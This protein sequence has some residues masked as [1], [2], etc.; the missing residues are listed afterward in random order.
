M[1]GSLRSLVRGH[2]RLPSRNDKKRRGVTAIEFALVA[3]AFVL[4]LIGI[5]EMSLVL[6]AEHL[7]ENAAYNASRKAKTGYVAE[8]K[9]QTETV[10][11]VLL[12]R[13][14]GLSPLLDPAKVSVTWTS[15]GELSDIG[16]PDEG[17][18][19]MGT[20]SQVVV[21]TV[22]YPWKLFTPLIGSII[23]NEDNIITLSSRI[24]VRN[25]PYD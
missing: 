10:M 8:G 14:G 4:L 12:T 3:P 25:E 6:L 24:V 11:N 19:S 22:D 21:Y 16:Q 1:L 5:T 17:A 13:L 9:T 15:Y 20:P 2:K 7:L 23:G 18:V